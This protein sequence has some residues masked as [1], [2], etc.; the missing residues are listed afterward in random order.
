M[1]TPRTS[2]SQGV[3][4]PSCNYEY[5]QRFMPTPRTTT[6]QRVSIPSYNYLP[7][8]GGQRVKSNF[9]VS[10]VPWIT[11]VTAVQRTRLRTT[12]AVEI[13]LTGKKL[14]SMFPLF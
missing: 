9:Q 5:V 8:N 1:D 2:T 10:D 7:H 6:P 12:N 13:L 4:I 11:P 14:S 3:G